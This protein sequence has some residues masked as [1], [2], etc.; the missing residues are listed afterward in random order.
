MGLE[1]ELAAIGQR[2]NVRSLGLLE[3]YGPKPVEPECSTSLNDSEQ[4]ANDLDVK[5]WD[6]VDTDG[7]R[8]EGEETD[9]WRPKDAP[10]STAASMGK[11]G[12]ASLDSSG[13]F[14]KGVP[15]VAPIKQQQ[16]TEVVSFLT[17]AILAQHTREINEQQMFQ[18]SI[19]QWREG[20]EKHGTVLA[21]PVV[22]GNDGQGWNRKMAGLHGEDQ[23]AEDEAERAAQGRVLFRPVQG[24][25]ALP[26][27]RPGRAIFQSARRA[28]SI[29]RD[30]SMRSH[31]HGR[32]RPQTVRVAAPIKT[33]VTNLDVAQTRAQKEEAAREAEKLA[34]EAARRAARRAAAR[35]AALNA[36]KQAEEDAARIAREQE[37]EQADAD[38]Q[39]VA[40]VAR[41]AAV[42]REAA[43]A[44][45]RK[46]QPIFNV[47][48]KD[49]KTRAS[50]LPKSSGASA[51]ANASGS[52]TNQP[53]SRPTS[54]R[55][56]TQSPRTQRSVTPALSEKGSTRSS[57]G[58]MHPASRR[59]RLGSGAQPGSRLMSQSHR[60]ANASSPEPVLRKASAQSSSSGGA[61]APATPPAPPTPPPSQPSQSQLTPGMAA[62][63]AAAAAAKAKPAAAV[64]TGAPAFADP[65]P[66]GAPCP[67]PPLPL[68]GSGP[69]QLA[70]PPAPAVAVGGPL[71]LVPTAAVPGTAAHVAS[72]SSLT[73]PATLSAASKGG[74]GPASTAERVYVPAQR[75]STSDAS[76]TPTGGGGSKAGAA[77]AGGRK[78]PGGVA[79]GVSSPI[80]AS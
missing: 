49:S 70:L 13:L 46:R 11:A 22:L 60:G 36:A 77:K 79:G 62:A 56:N 67:P 53:S 52:T 5:D 4:M 75:L 18:S 35:A 78:P 34:R 69:S 63:N 15:A 44:A 38:A 58:T 54:Q 29:R 23:V 1:A 9:D 68:N 47:D 57:P 42:A 17:E 51:S 74:H 43:Q 40:Q 32:V 19:A 8:P 39:R 65:S 72:S 26:S 20:A 50:R 73:S 24:A 7:W 66:T 76:G 6:A 10:V 25:A 64:P 31:G 55:T 2:N 80:A 28:I 48:E 30:L 71:P 21:Q 61:A 41:R 33:G 3:R 14:T 45:R 27:G 12:G 37:Q 16:P 59:K